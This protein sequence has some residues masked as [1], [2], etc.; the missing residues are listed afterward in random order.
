MSKVSTYAHIFKRGTV[1]TE[2]TAG[3][4]IRLKDSVKHFNAHKA[5]PCTVYSFSLVYSDNPTTMA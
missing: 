2:I 4:A 5:I 3:S 1:T